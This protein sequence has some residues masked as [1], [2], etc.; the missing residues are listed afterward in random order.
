MN[1]TVFKLVKTDLR[2]SNKYYIIIYKTN[3]TLI[4]SFLIPFALL[5]AFNAKIVMAMREASL[6]KETLN[7]KTSDKG[8]NLQNKVDHLS[9]Q[10]PNIKMPLSEGL[11]TLILKVTYQ[12]F[13]LKK[14]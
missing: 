11:K 10:C 8:R 1:R 3:L 9:K 5:I 13:E 14:I 12:S 2:T 4:I 6:V 7:V